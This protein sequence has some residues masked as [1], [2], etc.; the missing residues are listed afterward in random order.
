MHIVIYAS[1]IPF[2]GETINERSLGGSESAA[3]YVAKEFA[4]RGNRV[5]VFTESEQG[6]V[7]DGVNYLWVGPKD[8]QNPLGQNWHFYCTNTPHDVNI[9]QRLPGGFCYAIQSKINLW[10]AHDIALKRSNDFIMAQGWNTT[11]ILPV[12]NWFKQQIADTWLVNPDIIDP[13]H[14]GVDYTLF[15]EFEL[16]H[17]HL[18]AVADDGIT[19][20]YSSR[21]ERGLEN[22]VMPGGIMDQLQDKAPHIKLK[23]CGYKHPDADEKL[24]GF[25]KMLHDQ[26]D[27]L[28]NC[29]HIGSLTKRELY[30]LMC[31]E[32]DVW[33]YPTEFE[34]VSCIT[35]ME[36]M[37]AGLSIVTTPTAALPETIGD[38]ENCV[39]FKNK[40]DGVDVDKFVKWLCKFNN[41]F[42][43]K[44]RRP[45]TWQRTTD[46][47]EQIISDC[48]DRAN[49]DADAVGRHYLRNSDILALR[50][51]GYDNLPEGITE[52]VE[53]LYGGWMFDQEAYAEHYADGTEEMY[54]GPSFTYESEDFKQHPRFA[55]V[56]RFIQEKLSDDD[57]VIDYGC[58]HGHFTNY[59]AHEFSNIDFTG[60]DVS[61]AA[62]KT[63]KDK[64]SEMELSNA[65]YY[66]GD[67]LDRHNLPNHPK[68]CD[69][70]VLGEILEHVP[71]P[72]AFME[73]VK[74]RVGSV[75]VVITT[76]FGPWEEMS[77]KRDWPKRFHLHHLERADLQDLFGHYD[78]FSVNCLPAGH[79]GFGEAIGWYITTF[80][81]T[82][83]VAAKPIDYER[84]RHETVP[85]QTVSFCAIAKDAEYDLPRL[86]RSIE[87][88]VDEIII[89]VDETTTD[90]TREVI[91]QFE[92]QLIK[93]HRSPRMDFTVFTIPSP[94]EIGF[95]EARNL[96]IAKAS[97][98]WVMWADA[99][100]E[101]VGA[102]RLPK[103]LQNNGWNGYGVA[104]HHFS[105]EPTQVLSTDFPVRIFRRNPD[106]S[107]EGVVH[108]HPANKKDPN[109]GVGF[110]WVNQELHFS[111]L[112]YGTEEIRR[113]RF[114]R[115]V[116]LMAR[117]REKN[118]NRILG[119]FL[120]IRDLA[121][122]NRF[123]LEQTKGGITPEMQ[124]RALMGLKLW[125][126]T[127]DE[128]GD[129][130]QV[131][132]MVKDHLEFYDV[133]V[134]CMD[135]G[136][137]FRFKFASGPNINA[138][139][140][141]EVPELSARF[142]NTR[143]LD[144][145]LSVLINDEVK[146]YEEKYL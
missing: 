51:I 24:G 91:E 12:S 84:K 117:D 103:Y 2:N 75:P 76:P 19:L 72:V 93:D 89:G 66:L 132:R 112:G 8:Q 120:W 99:D 29:E 134:N 78:D 83:D 145:F 143:H 34:E 6:G 85:R 142:L 119:R 40:D 128:Y 146:S 37:A 127:L 96:T 44:P 116:S 46:E 17:N 60:I 52:E 122:M 138:P 109:E 35:A 67:W 139:Q 137:T 71:D 102:E 129:H 135:R 130:P 70:L 124:E 18:Q 113:R 80:T 48:F 125:E 62:V 111:H 74:E 87:P 54:D 69:L 32:A 21:P 95:D 105:V 53:T 94:L 30:K 23:V 107:F 42:R 5:C 58:A 115:N 50:E 61:P 45:Y 68:Q 118:P 82:D 27:A 22:L 65:N 20:L 56:A 10:W 13:I 108:E 131:K 38:Y 106:V 14:N 63:A 3:Y 43:R 49:N 59:L 86:L 39:M 31:E 136:F 57:W 104:Q 92:A 101:F 79:S 97:K 81:L 41:K 28:P 36:C 144:K 9:I 100:E 126:E 33:C 77:Y 73:V 25:Y 133:L 121:L 11:R 26:V 4:E 98:H 140:L 64:A 114:Q 55:E 47:I 7:V 88:V 141:H 110:A 16:K 90:N 123:E 1:G 15:D